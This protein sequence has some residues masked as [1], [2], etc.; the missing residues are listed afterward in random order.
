MRLFWSLHLFKFA[1]T[2]HVAVCDGG[3]GAMG[4]PVEYIQLNMSPMNHKS[5]N[6]VIA[7]HRERSKKNNEVIYTIVQNIS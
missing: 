3:S 2:G 4:H 6:T 5:V 7:V 1:Y